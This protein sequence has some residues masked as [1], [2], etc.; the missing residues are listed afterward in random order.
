MGATTHDLNWPP[1][2]VPDHGIIVELLLDLQVAVYPGGSHT[3]SHLEKCLI[4]MKEV[5]ISVSGRRVPHERPRRGLKSLVGSRGQSPRQWLN[6]IE[7]KEDL[8]GTQMVM[9]KTALTPAKV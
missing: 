3:K 4:F 7:R 2:R 1:L 8:R 6:P 5:D 9:S